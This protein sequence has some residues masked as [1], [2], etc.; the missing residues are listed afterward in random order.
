[1]LLPLHLLITRFHLPAYQTT[2][3]ASIRV[4]L[5]EGGEEDF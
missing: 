4:Q 5:E 2:L 3:N 1:M